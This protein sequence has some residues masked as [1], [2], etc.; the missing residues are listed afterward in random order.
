MSQDNPAAVPATADTM[1]APPI[2]VTVL[3]GFLGSGKPTLLA[4]LLRDPALTNTAVIVNEFGEVGLD[5]LLLEHSG[6]D[7]IELDGGCLCC[8]VRGDL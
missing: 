2:P 5:H 6:E 8:T 4:R 7:L 3:T 1:D